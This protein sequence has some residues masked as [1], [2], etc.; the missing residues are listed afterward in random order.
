MGAGGRGAAGFGPGM[1]FGAAGA[2]DVLSAAAG[3][4][5]AGAAGAA[6]AAGAGALGFGADGLGADGFED[7]AS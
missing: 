4:D 3:L 1:A 7:L 6:A 5:S 2:A